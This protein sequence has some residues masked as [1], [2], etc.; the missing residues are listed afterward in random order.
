V[1]AQDQAINTNYFRKKIL[2]QQTDSKCQLCK[3]HEET[4]DHLISGCPIWAKNEYIIRH[5]R[6]CTHLHY[7][8]YKELGIETTENWYTHNPES[9]CEHEDITVLWNQEVQTDR[10]WETGQL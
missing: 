6:V 4:I 2:K 7:S 10:F 8:I 9:V 3:E 5:D 1:A